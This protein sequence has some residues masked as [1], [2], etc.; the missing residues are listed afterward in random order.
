MKKALL[1]TALVVPLTLTGCVVSVGGDGE[2]MHYS[3]WEDRE[4]KNRRKISNLTLDMS[5][6]NVKDSFG[7][8]DFN[9]LHARGEDNVQV[10]YYR[11]QRTEGDGVTTKDEC[12][13]L[14]FKNGMLVGWG[15]TAYSQ[16]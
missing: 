7:V 13:P 3:S 11:T 16:I 15:D 9:E 2:G 1:V 6:T 10:L 14:V 12:T 8:P 5:I 4:Y